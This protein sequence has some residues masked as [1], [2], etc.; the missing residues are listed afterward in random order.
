MNEINLSSPLPY[1]ENHPAQWYGRQ[2]ERIGWIGDIFSLQKHEKTPDL[3][4]PVPYFQMR[5]SRGVGE[6][7][8]GCFSPFWVKLNEKSNWIDSDNFTD[9]IFFR[10]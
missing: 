7:L 2:D 5:S 1:P 4:Y 8:G 9:R 10:S 6:M 3:P